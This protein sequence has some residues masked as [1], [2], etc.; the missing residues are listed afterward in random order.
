[1]RRG[2]DPA[3][4]EINPEPSIKPNRCNWIAILKKRSKE[5]DMTIKYNRITPHLWFNDQAEEAARFYVSI[6]KNSRIRQISRYGGAGARVSG[7]TEGTVMSVSFDLDGQE[8][9]ALNGGPVFSF[10]PAIS[11]I[12]LCKNQKET[13]AFW[14]KLSEGGEPGQCG[15]LT[16]RYGVSWQIVPDSALK[17]FQTKDRERNERVMNALFQMKKID[18]A[19]LE[20][21]AGLPARRAG[22]RARTAAGRS[23]QKR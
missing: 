23:K 1:M 21:A 6:F 20:A 7:R 17:L 14:G 22:N 5:G 8:F 9:V 10:T 19:A 16:D 3:R 11:F 12:V 13:D 4:P 18:V 2:G 15:W